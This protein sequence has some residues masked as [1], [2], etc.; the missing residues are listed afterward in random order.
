MIENSYSSIEEIIK[1]NNHYVGGLIGYAIDNTVVTNSFSTTTMNSTGGSNI[2]GLIGYPS[3]VSGCT[4]S[5]YLEGNEVMLYSS[6][7]TS[8]SSDGKDYFKGNLTNEP[9]HNWP[10]LIWVSEVNNYPQ[11]IN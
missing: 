4:N 2:G 6:S 8:V 5:Y 3:P 7:P 1:G 11:L 10:T 9:M